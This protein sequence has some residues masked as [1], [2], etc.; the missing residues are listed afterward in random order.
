MIRLL[1]R[2]CKKRSGKPF[3]R[4]TGVKRPDGFA[5]VEIMIVSSILGVLFAV[6][7]PA[8]SRIRENARTNICISNQ[9]AIFTAASMYMIAEANDL[10]AIEGDKERLDALIEGGYLRGNKWCECPASNDG[11]NDDYTM[12][13]ENNFISDVNCNENTDEHVWP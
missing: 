4:K 8:Y 10:E 9:K 7:M 3:M 13:F 6:A 12:V 1:K 2:W 11:D 5:L